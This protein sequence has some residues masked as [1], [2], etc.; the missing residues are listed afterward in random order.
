LSQQR[1]S[2]ELLSVH[3]RTVQALHARLALALAL[4]RAQQAA[5][6]AAAASVTPEAM[7]KLVSPVMLKQVEVFCR[8]VAEHTIVAGAA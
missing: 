2:V 4:F 3:G 7:V 1:L 6:Q 5:E 8:M